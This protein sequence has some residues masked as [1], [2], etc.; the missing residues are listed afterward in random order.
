LEIGRK[1]DVGRIRA[2]VAAASRAILLAVF[3][4]GGDDGEI[5][6]SHELSSLIAKQA[7]PAFIPGE[8]R[9]RGESFE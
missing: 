7:A 2:N 6:K 4:N 5:T 8:C 9:S 1:P 3:G